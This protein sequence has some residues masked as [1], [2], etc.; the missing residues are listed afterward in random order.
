MRPCEL[1]DLGLIPYA[2]AGAL[3]KDLVDKRKR[4]ALDR[5]VGSQ[6]AADP[7]ALP[8]VPYRF[9]ESIARLSAASAA[10]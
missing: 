9:S 3:Q 7:L 2:A 5:L 6:N 10:S 4:A 8:Q 1:T